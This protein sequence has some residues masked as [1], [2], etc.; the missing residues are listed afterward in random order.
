MK[1]LFGELDARGLRLCAVRDTQLPLQHIT[2]VGQSE[3]YLGWLTPSEW[4][5]VAELVRRSQP[6]CL[7]REWAFALADGWVRP[8]CAGMYSD[9]P[10][11]V[12]EELCDAGASYRG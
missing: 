3:P 2:T 5:Q 9:L 6:L 12:Y 1:Y 7:G 4:E 11:R 10:A 8:A